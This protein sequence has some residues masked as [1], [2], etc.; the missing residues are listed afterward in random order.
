MT[1]MDGHGIADDELDAIID[2]ALA[3]DGAGQDATI[4][5]LGIGRVPVSAQLV[6]KAAGI[7]AGLGIA[8]RI[9]NRLDPT[10][11]VDRAQQDGAAVVA[12]S[13][14]ATVRGSAAAVLGGERVA[15]NLL[16]RLSGIATLT[17]RFVERV[18]GSGVGILDTRKTTPGLRKLER[19]AVRLGG[20][21]NHRFN[22]TDMILIKENHFRAAGGA[23]TVREI[24]ER[25]RS[26]T[27]VEIEVD[28]PAFLKRMLG[29]PVDRIMLDNFSPEEVTKAV[30]AIATHRKDH[31]TF[32]PEIEASGGITLQNVR[33]YAIAG[34]DYIS[35]GALTHSAPALDISL[36]VIPDE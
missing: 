30:A 26:S 8:T 15:L 29:V 10:T 5:A 14:I 21:K 1:V 7:V 4:Q 9:F 2:A 16:Q 36:E 3:E 18:R 27:P 31:P 28:S 33:D 6:V 32:K 20:G 35:I 23:E 25:L 22:L 34:L 17:S 11:V 24:L 19:Y 12:G 13:P